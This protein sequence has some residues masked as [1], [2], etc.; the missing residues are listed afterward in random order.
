MCKIVRSHSKH[1]RNTLDSCGDLQQQ[2]AFSKSN[3]P[4]ASS[5]DRPQSQSGLPHLRTMFNQTQPTDWTHFSRNPQPHRHGATE[6]QTTSALRWWMAGDP[7]GT[8]CELRTA[9]HLSASEANPSA[10]NG[11]PWQRPPGFLPSPSTPSHPPSCKKNLACV[12]LRHINADIDPHYIGP[13]FLSE[14]TRSVVA[15]L[16]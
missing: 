11:S 16:H 14:R 7:R 12:P 8:N 9:S 4:R 15:D 5:K 13:Q 10:W 6:A 2:V 3:H 1:T